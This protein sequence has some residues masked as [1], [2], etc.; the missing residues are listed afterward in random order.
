[1]CVYNHKRR[2]IIDKRMHVLK[3]LIIDVT[4]KCHIYAATEHP[5]DLCLDLSN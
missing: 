1:M 2:Y 5:I 3:L 4:V